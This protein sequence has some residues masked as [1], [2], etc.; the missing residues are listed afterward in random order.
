M[1]IIKKKLNTIRIC[2]LGLISIQNLLLFASISS[3]FIIILYFLFPLLVNDFQILKNTVFIIRFIS[4]AIFLYFIIKIVISF[5]SIHYLADKIEKQFPQHNEVLLSSL[6]LENET[7]YSADIIS[8][9]QQQAEKIA[10]NLKLKE[11]LSF[12]GVL[13]ALYYFIPIIVIVI[14]I[15]LTNAQTLSDTITG[16]TNPEKFKPHY[17]KFIDVLPGNI[18]ILRGSQQKISVKN[19]YPKLSY[20]LFYKYEKYWKKVE[21]D[22]GEYTF[23]NL[24][25]NMDYCVKSIRF[26]GNYQAISDTFTITVIEK[27]VIKNL[28]L[29]Y[30]YP[31]YSGLKTKVQDNSLGNIIALAG[32][33]ILLELTVNNPLLDARII[34]SDGQTKPLQQKDKNSRGQEFKT[35]FTVTK[36][37]TY[38]FLFEDILHNQ[39]KII[40]RTITIV[41]DEKPCIEIKKPAR[42]KILAQSMTEEIGFFATDDYG[43]SQIDVNYKKN[44]ENSISKTIR[45]NV[46]TT[47]LKDS[48]ILDLNDLRLLPGDVVSYYLTVYDNRTYFKR[49]QGKSRTY[50]LRFPSIEEMYD[51]IRKTEQDQFSQFSKNLE[52]SQKLNKKFEDLRRKF[53]KKEDYTWEEKQDLKDILN[54]QK[55]LSEQTEKIAKDYK[56]FIDEIEK[57]R[58][59]SDETLEKLKQIQEI[60]EEISTPELQQA[61]KKLQENLQNISKQEMLKALKNFK[62]SQEDFMKRLD[63]TLKLLKS[64]QMEQKMQ[65]LVQQAEELEKMQKDLDQKA[66]DKIDSN[67]PMDDLAQKQDEISK[68]LEQMKKEIK[69][70]AEQLKKEGNK[71]ASE[72]LEKTLSEMNK[73][74]L[75]E[76]LSE[77]SKMMQQNQK[78]G[79]SGKQQQTEKSFLKLKQNLQQA[80]GMMQ[81][82]MQMAL[83]QDLEKAF[84]RLLYFSNEQENYL[85]SPES[86]PFLILDQE[87]A[88]FEGLKATIKQLYRNPQISLV[89]SP[90]FAIHAGQTLNTCEELFDDIN[91]RRN[92]KVTKHKN[93]IFA[94]INKMLAD[95]LNSKRQMSQGGGGGMQS[96]MQQL[97]QMSKQQNSIN[98]LTDM[99]YQEMMQQQG[100]LSQ[101]QRAMMKRLAAEQ[102][103]LGENLK[104]TLEENPEAKKA[105]GRLDELSKEMKE[106]A[107]QI[108]KGKIDTELLDRQKRIL[109]RMLDAQRSI[110]KRDFS[111]KRKAETPEQKLYESP[112]ELK[113]EKSEFEYKD[114]LKYLNENYPPEYHK[115]IKK[116]LE[117]IEK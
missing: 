1:N 67:Q 69:E 7:R 82:M 61:M 95:I 116:Y 10:N 49:Q 42:D 52:E 115:L 89:L 109:S 15:G 37:L 9:N 30:I 27:P 114:F 25:S 84:V 16:L 110:H 107:E 33:K 75:S 36:N 31:S 65:K 105:M 70:L 87:Y 2:L 98:M 51:E 3:I 76:Q 80:Q 94:G 99:M 112:P 59:V 53:L 71:Q 117:S 74:N 6:E 101:Q 32:T 60:M 34:F 11:I 12:K 22:K 93:D 55:Q 47:T 19:Y 96:L 102:E 4:L 45:E 113:L 108:K 24:S 100:Q 106:I 44:D 64:V 50:L 104:R 79:M 46:R 63:N 14:V 88:I 83:M 81:S 8:A 78:S 48:F 72:Q 66:Q 77:L 57:N 29:T 17:E 56:K 41:D 111:K 21:M 91:N 39:N 68:K 38:H 35:A 62:F 73:D 40:E 18:T 23:Y 13:S 43:I 92:S 5:H 28:K 97:Q 58:A 20:L 85:D 86:D 90:L 54:K 103:R 26:G